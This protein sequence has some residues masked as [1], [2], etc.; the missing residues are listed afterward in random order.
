M[1]LLLSTVIVFWNVENFFDYKIKSSIS[2]YGWNAS[3]FYSK[4]KNVGKVILSLSDS[5]GNPP[6]FVGLAEVDSK[7]TLN[8]I[9]HSP[10]LET[11]GYRFVHFDSPDKRGIDCAL[12][13][14][15]H[16]PT[17]AHPIPLTFEGKPVKS[18]DLLLVEFDS[19]AVLVCH[20]PSKR[21]GS[22]AAMRLRE[23][24]MEMIDSVAYAS[25]KPIVVV[26]DF[27]DT[28]PSEWKYV[29]ELQATGSE[30]SIKFQGKWERI[31]RCL[32]S[33]SLNAAMTTP[34][35]DFLLE[36]DKTY[37]GMKPHRTHSGPRYIGGLSDHLPIVITLSDL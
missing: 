8:A 26:G 24:A 2:D 15:K 34:A 16:I 31:D 10:V 27:N 5:M 17:D 21:G 33:D 7:R 28:G 11:Y 13:Y 14:R 30:G 25:E 4:A 20:L 37:G 29:R 18:R 3:R 1:I 32:V 23:R 19:L 22:A 35:L 9:V 12:L 6:D 36:K